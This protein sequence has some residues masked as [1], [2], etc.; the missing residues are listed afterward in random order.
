MASGAKQLK[1]ALRLPFETAL[2]WAACAALRPLPRGVVCRLAE[3][4]GT[5]GFRLAGSLREVGMANLDVVYGHRLS[6]EEK[7]RIL[8][9]STRNVALVALDT[10]WFSYRTAERVRQWVR[11]DVD[12][13]ALFPPN[14]AAV[15]LTGHFGN[16]E[17]LGHATAL[18]GYPLTSVATPLKNRAVD[19]LL[20]KAREVV[21]QHIIERDG[22]VR[23]MMQALKS[24]GRVALLLDQNT[25]LMEGGIFV[26]FFGVPATVSPAAA[27]L[28]CHT[29]SRLVFGFCIPQNNGSYRVFS[30]AVIEPPRLSKENARETITALTQQ[31]A[32]V[33]EKVILDSPDCWLW[34]YKRW[35]HIRPGDAH[36]GYPFYSSELRPDLIPPSFRHDNA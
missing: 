27:S 34:M 21:G 32:E 6:V 24:N 15:C 14:R 8:L 22:A 17:I 36:V 7:S 9:H 16:W 29:K 30:P 4:L 13:S 23:R 26:S 3:W 5:V 18:A 2:T 31:I 1:R 35:K 33:F 12:L 28:A 25:S 19:R 11:L 20:R 10:I